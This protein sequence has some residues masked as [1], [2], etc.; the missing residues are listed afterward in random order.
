MVEKGAFKFQE[1]GRVPRF[2]EV[3]KKR[4]FVI[5]KGNYGVFTRNGKREKAFI[6]AKA[7]LHSRAINACLRK[8][9]EKERK[10]REKTILSL[11]LCLR[12]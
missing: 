12:P 2:F 9:G 6:G 3:L 10:K 5:K 1:K 11:Y 4:M 8:S 7:L